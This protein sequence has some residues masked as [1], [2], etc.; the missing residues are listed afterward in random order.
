[1][2]EVS[3]RREEAAAEAHGSIVPSPDWDTNFVLLWTK[4]TDIDCNSEHAAQATYCLST[5][6]ASA[7]RTWGA[8]SPCSAAAQA[9]QRS[10]VTAGRHFAQHFVQGG[11]GQSGGHDGFLHPSA[12]VLGFEND[13]D[14]LAADD[15]VGRKLQDL[16][17]E[18]PPE[19]MRRP[20]TTGKRSGAGAPSLASNTEGAL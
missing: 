2:L 19:P 10:C 17:L 6:A 18:P 9:E 16:G 13:L 3:I 20:R 4:S 5:G 1:M 8:A 11:G 12:P 14:G 7:H 15:K